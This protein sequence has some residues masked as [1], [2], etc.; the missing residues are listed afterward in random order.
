MRLTPEGEELLT[1]PFPVRNV[2]CL[3]FGGPDYT[4]IFVT[5]ASA[6]NPQANGELSGS[7]FHLNL[8]VPGRAEFR[9]AL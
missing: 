8:G 4:D 6:G 1:I 9:S 7:L 3:T 5:T 2:S